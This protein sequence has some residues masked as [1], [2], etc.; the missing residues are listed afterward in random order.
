[1]TEIFLLSSASRIFLLLT[2]NVC[3]VTLAVDCARSFGLLNKSVIALFFKISLVAETVFIAISRTPLVGAYHSIFFALSGY[4]LLVPVVTLVWMFIRTKKFVYLFDCLAVIVNL[5]FFF[6]IDYWRYVYI[7]SMGYYFV[8]VVVFAVG[9]VIMFRNKPGRYMVKEA[10]D[11]LTSGIVFAN[12][13][14]QISFINCSMHEYFSMLGIDEY[15]RIDDIWSDIENL[16]EENGRKISPASVMLKVGDSYLVFNCGVKQHNIEQLVCRNVTEEEL[17]YLE[18]EK[19]RQKEMRLQTELENT[20][21]DIN[22]IESEKELL[23]IKGNLHD[24]MAQRLSI[25]H[26]I[27]NYNG[28]EDVDLKKIKQFIRTMMPEMYGD[29]ILSFRERINELIGS[30]AIIGVKL[31]IAPDVYRLKENSDVVLKVIRECTTNAVR[32]GGASVVTVKSSYGVNGYTLTVTD[33]GVSGKDNGYGNGIKGMRYAV[34]SAG[35]TLS[36]S[37]APSFTVTVCLPAVQL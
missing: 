23:R 32:H 2:L 17:V 19:D 24:V 4:L 35:G 13:Y 18:L 5:P 20:L 10:F 1:M 37:S 22:Y 16:A 34:E 14:G 31:R 27:V 11:S 21:K 6:L 30:F 7:F 29:N 15:A 3:A 26:G 12:Y 33:N 25:L 9:R 8:R 36:V 28:F